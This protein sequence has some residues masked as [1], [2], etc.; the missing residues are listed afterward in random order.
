MARGLAFASVILL[1]IT[2]VVCSQPPARVSAS[3]LKGAQVDA[4]VRAILEH[5]C[6]DC[7]SD[8]IRYPWYHS[9]PVISSIIKND[10]TRG[11]EQLNFSR[12]EK[13][14]RLQRQRSLTGIANQVKDRLMPLPEYLK[15]HPSATLSDADVG[16]IF[17]WAQAERLRLIMEGVK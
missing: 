3:F 10:V 4:R 11:R 8:D 13:Y 2:L 12:W 15:L 17:E 9:L 7:H 1:G 14:S 16:V 5:S 6:R